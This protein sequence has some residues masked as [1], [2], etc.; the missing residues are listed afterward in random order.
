[1]T[2]I[3]TDGITI[4]ADGRR[5]IGNELVC[6]NERK[7]IVRNGCVYAFTGDFAAFEPAIQW[8]ATGAAPKNVPQHWPEQGGGWT[9]IVIQY[10]DRRKELTLTAYQAKI[11][12]PVEYPF[13][14]AFG[15]GCE[16]ALGAMDAGATPLGA[17]Q[18]AAHRNVHTGGE[19]VEV[20][21]RE[22]L[23]LHRKRGA[24]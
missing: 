11:P 5:T 16:Y 6:D 13:P 21:I 15:S 8:H 20:D 18:I 22:A 23:E 7:L 12:Y 24:E 19:I 4:V 3:A 10:S 17:V 9:L 14:Q 2:T 1:M